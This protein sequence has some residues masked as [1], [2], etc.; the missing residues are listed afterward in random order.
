M[1]VD[2]FSMSTLKRLFTQNSSVHGISHMN[3]SKRTVM[4]LFMSQK[5]LTKSGTQAKHKG[6]PLMIHGF[7]V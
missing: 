6:K 4:R 3:M 1:Q 2:N 7:T 5:A